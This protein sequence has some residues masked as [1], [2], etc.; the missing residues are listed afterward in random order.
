MM[1]RNKGYNKIVPDCD[2]EKKGMDN[3]VSIV[4]FIATAFQKER[5]REEEDDNKN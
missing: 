4:K 3:Y 1:E 2:W 5:K